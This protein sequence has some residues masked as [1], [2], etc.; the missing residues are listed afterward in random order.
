MENPRFAEIKL[1]FLGT[2]G[3]IE[4]A[5]KIPFRNPNFIALTLI[6]S[7][8]LFCMRLIHELPYNYQPSW[9]MKAIYQ[10]RILTYDGGNMTWALN[11]TIQILEVY[12]FCLVDFLSALTTIYA[13]SII[14]TSNE[15]STMGLRNLLRNSITKTR[16]HE[17]MFTFL[18]VSYLCSL[19]SNVVDYWRYAR[20]LLSS[21][22]PTP[23]LRGLHLIVYGVAFAKWAEYSAWWNLS[24]VVSILEENRGFE[25]I[26]ASSKLTKGNRLRG[27]IWMLLYSV[28]SFKLPSLLATWTFP[29][30]LAYYYLDTSFLCLGKVINWVVLTVYYYDCKNCRNKVAISS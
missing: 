20:P 23:S 7:F 9:I 12:L 13:A 21:G 25:A 30:I 2:V 28:W 27:L 15:R 6:T 1:W 11:L 14:C 16:W 3:L 19:S 26:S 22:C 8:P 24:V 10:L 17:R 29:H 18:Y 4:S 5:M